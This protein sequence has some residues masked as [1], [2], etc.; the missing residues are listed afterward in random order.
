MNTSKVQETYTIDLI[1]DQLCSLDPSDIPLSVDLHSGDTIVFNYVKHEL[2]Q[3]TF[4]FQLNTN[5][6]NINLDSLFTTSDLELPS[7][8]SCSFEASSSKTYI[9][10]VNQE[11]P[12][13]N[14]SFSA[15]VRTIVT[16]EIKVNPPE[17]DQLSS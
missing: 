15:A 5:D 9:L 3:E 6:Q 4:I 7:S 13:A 10:F 2:C 1:V 17:K 8:P 11:S 16:M 12:T 14:A